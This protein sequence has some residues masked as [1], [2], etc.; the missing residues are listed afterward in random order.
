MK[1]KT[2]EAPRPRRRRILAAVENRD[3][4]GKF[5]KGNRAAAGRRGRHAELRAALA[6]AVAP[7]EV[8]EILRAMA[9]RALGG[10]VAA[11]I[12]VLD[13]LLGRPAREALPAG[14]GIDLGALDTLADIRR[15]TASLARAAASGT[16]DVAAARDLH[17]QLVDLA[18]LI[19]ASRLADR[20][21]DLEAR[22]ASGGAPHPNGL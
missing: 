8:R 12:A 4:D 21:A 18:E 9:K 20:V 17:Q 19:L 2:K 10:D 6:S 16:V 15:A 1:T 5:G 14:D 3:T 22:M 7:D 13:R 11:G